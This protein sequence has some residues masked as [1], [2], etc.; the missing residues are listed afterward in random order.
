MLEEYLQLADRVKA[1]PRYVEALAKRG[2]GVAYIKRRND[3]GW[4]AWLFNGY[5]ASGTE[6]D[7]FVH[8]RSAVGETHIIAVLKTAEAMR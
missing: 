7:L 4:R 2:L 5:L 8:G 1:D 6:D 3:P